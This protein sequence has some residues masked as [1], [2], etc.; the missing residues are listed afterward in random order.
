MSDT[1][2][3][4]STYNWPAALKVCLDSVCIQS[5]MPREVIICDDGSGEETRSLLDDVKKKFPVPLIHVWHPDEGFRLSGIRNKG[6]AAATGEYLIQIDG[7]L[8]LHRH[9]VKDHISFRQKGAFTTGSRALLSEKNTLRLIGNAYS[10]KL[11][12]FG[13]KNFFNGIRI[14]LAQQFL[15]SRYKNK[16]RHLYYVKGCNMAFWRKDILAINGYN[17]DFT[18]WGSEDSEIAIRLM[19]MGIRKRF[20][21]LGGICYH[22]HHRQASRAMEDVNL[23]IMNRTIQEKKIW[24]LNGINKYLIP[25]ERQV[26]NGYF[27]TSDNRYSQLLKEG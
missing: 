26:I 5:V 22:L 6:M 27:S 18:G 4:I 16:G 20:L 14:P 11:K 9:F 15:A 17:E 23:Q 7:D 10:D 25:A 21:K 8:Q 13:N 2:L 1:S 19:N 3:L 12:V 24:T